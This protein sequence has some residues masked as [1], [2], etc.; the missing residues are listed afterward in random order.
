MFSQLPDEKPNTSIRGTRITP[1][2]QW[3]ANMPAH[4][5]KS[6]QH[7]VPPE[8]RGITLGY[9]DGDIVSETKE[10]PF[11]PTSHNK[12]IFFNQIDLPVTAFLINVVHGDLEEAKVMLDKN[13]SLVL[14]SGQITDY[15]GRTIK[16]TAYQIA[17][18]ADDV[19]RAAHPDEGMA[20]MI[21]DYFIKALSDDEKRAN[22]E[23]SKQFKE[24]FPEK[25]FPEYYEADKKKRAEIIKRKEVA[26]PD[27]KA[28]E[29]LANTILHADAKEIK[30][31]LTGEQDQ[32]G[33]DEY[34][35]TVSGECAK[36]LQA[37][38]DYLK[39]QTVIKKGKHFNT[40]LLVKALEKYIGEQYDLFGGHLN[41]PKNLLFLR[42][43]IGYIERYLPANL[44]QAFCQGLGYAARQSL[45]RNLKLKDSSF[46]YPRDLSS[47]SGLGFNHAVW[48]GWDRGAVDMIGATIDGGWSRSWKAYVEQKQ[49]SF[50]CLQHVKKRS[51]KNASCMVL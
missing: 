35:L 8:I 39:P 33:W 34:I 28:L 22:E 18:G 45:E 1:V 46:F 49:Q 23:I 17:L 25:E 31:T 21:R 47:S 37:F 16:G 2:P 51:K 36:A 13:P 44:A 40:Q 50:I 6:D 15:S 27:I 48:G 5:N 42:Q 12:F 7:T 41:N 38:R 19:S 29:T 26:D 10:Y 43:V 9:L 32:D 11:T 4:T 30:A 24:Q 3:H 20:D 14:Y